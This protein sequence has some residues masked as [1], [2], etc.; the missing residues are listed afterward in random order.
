VKYQLMMRGQWRLKQQMNQG[1]L[2]V[3]WEEP[4]YPMGAIQSEIIVCRPVVIHK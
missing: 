4:P 2:G 1:R 3:I